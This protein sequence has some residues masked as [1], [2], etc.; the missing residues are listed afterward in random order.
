M[1]IKKIKPEYDNMFLLC[2]YRPSVASADNLLKAPFKKQKQRLPK[3]ALFS[4]IVRAKDRFFI[5]RDE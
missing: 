5:W 3:E 1:T 2:H 4:Y